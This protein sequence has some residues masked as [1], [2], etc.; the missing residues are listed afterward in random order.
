MHFE[1]LWEKCESFHKEASPNDDARSIIEQLA[2]KVDFYK[3]VH[4]QEMPEEDL[5]KI[6]E[7]AMGEILLTLTA[8][9]LADNINTYEALNGALQYRSIGFYNQKY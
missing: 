3:A 8:L 1:E 6:K 9:S 5:R 7:R 2:M 4:K